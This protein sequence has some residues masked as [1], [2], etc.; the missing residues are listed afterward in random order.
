MYMAVSIVTDMRLDKNP[1]NPIMNMNSLLGAAWTKL[2]HEVMPKIRT[3][4]TIADQR[5]VLGLYHLSSVLV[6]F[7]CFYYCY[8]LLSIC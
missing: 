5:A 4:H 6:A 7:F 2:K 3:T 8:Q 1:S